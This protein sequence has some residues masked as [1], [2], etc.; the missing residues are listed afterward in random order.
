[1]RGCW[2]RQTGKLEVLVSVLACGFK[3]HFPHQ[4]KGHSIFGC[5]L[6]LYLG[7]SAKHYHRKKPHW[8][9]TKSLISWKRNLFRSQTGKLEVLVSVLACGFKSH[10]PHQ[11]K[12]HS[13]FGCPL[14]L[15]LGKSAKHYHRK[16]PHWNRTKSLISWKRNLFR[17]QTGKLEVLV[18][19]LA[20]GFKSHFPHQCKGHSIFG[21]PLFLFIEDLKI[22]SIKDSHIRIRTFR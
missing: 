8:N 11:C 15:Y 1:M 9:R 3:S 20:C 18:S 19:V 2:N 14:F 5:P 21:C 10:F 6:F 13:I 17:S 12:G 22:N 16:K 4:C 7:K